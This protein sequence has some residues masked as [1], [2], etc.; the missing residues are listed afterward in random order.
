MKTVL[1]LIAALALA[2]GLP[3]SMR[4]AEQGAEKNGEAAL[5]QLEE[6]WLHARDL[7]TLERIY[8]REF[9]HVRSDG[10]IFTREEDLADYRGMK[11]PP[12]AGMHRRFERLKV[13]MYG[14]IGIATGRTALTDQTGKPVRE[15]SFTDVFI[16]RG[17][18]WK[19]VS[20]QETPVKK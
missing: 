2:G 20:A 16:R 3:G 10:R 18:R 14:A 5:V 6:E 8:A 11:A 12:A 13:R 9:V 19:A 1:M 4:A 7:A 17:G 15:T